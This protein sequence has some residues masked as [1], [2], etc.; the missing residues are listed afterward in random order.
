VKTRLETCALIGHFAQS[1]I[2]ESA[3]T[4]LA[5]LARR[6]IRVWWPPMSPELRGAAQA[7]PRTELANWRIS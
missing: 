2:A 3:V 5:A 6:G 4:V 1:R 7:V